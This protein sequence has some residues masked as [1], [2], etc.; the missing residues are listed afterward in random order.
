MSFKTVCQYVTNY[1]ILLKYTKTVLKYITK[2]AL[3]LSSIQEFSLGIKLFFVL[4]TDM[5][6]LLILLA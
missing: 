4:M 1:K 3:R 6:T 5:L 2:A